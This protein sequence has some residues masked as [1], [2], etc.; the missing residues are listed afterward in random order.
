[1]ATDC[2]RLSEIW[3]DGLIGTVRTGSMAQFR[4]RMERFRKE[5]GH[6]AR[7]LVDTQ[8][9]SRLAKRYLSHVCDPVQGGEWRRTACVSRRSG[10]TG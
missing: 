1:M 3:E 5:D 10:R 8:Y 9:L 7:H 2:V 4:A 6:V